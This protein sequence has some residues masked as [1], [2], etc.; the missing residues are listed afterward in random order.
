MRASARVILGSVLGCKTRSYKRQD[1]LSSLARSSQ[2][3][4]RGS[5]GPWGRVLRRCSF[6]R[7]QLLHVL[8]LLA[9]PLW[10]RGRRVEDRGG[11]EGLELATRGCLLRPCE[12][13]FDGGF[14]HRCEGAR[15]LECLIEDL[16]A[17][18]PGDHDRGRQVQSVM[19][20]LDG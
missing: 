5:S 7:D 18:A 10:V 1:L 15:R 16:H 19:K 11:L 3:M 13:R 17:V 4:F 2:R 6:L 12:Q 14:V 8:G 20:T 9:E